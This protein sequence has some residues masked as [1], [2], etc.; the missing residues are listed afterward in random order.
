MR[1]QCYLIRTRTLSEQVNEKRSPNS[2]SYGRVNN[3]IIN[4]ASVTIFRITIF[5]ISRARVIIYLCIG[6][7]EFYQISGLV[8]PYDTRPRPRVN[9]RKKATINGIIYQIL[10]GKVDLIFTYQ[11]NF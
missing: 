4:C 11:L 9:I 7:L 2:I 5:V 10:N 3:V 1:I 8:C 6:K